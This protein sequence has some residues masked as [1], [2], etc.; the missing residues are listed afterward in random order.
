MLKVWINGFRDNCIKN[1]KFYFDMNKE[2]EW[3]N[4]EDVR[5][6]IKGIDNSIVIGD[7]AI[8]SPV[9]GGISVERLSHG[10]KATILDCVLDDCNIYML[11]DVVIIV[12]HFYMIYQ[13]RRT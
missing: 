1:P 4:R 8:Q 12:F 10:C 7:E 13:K 9:F 3:F 5:A 6:I 11:V 2:R